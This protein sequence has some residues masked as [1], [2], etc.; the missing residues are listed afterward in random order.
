MTLVCL[1]WIGLCMFGL[2]TADGFLRGSLLGSSILFGTEWNTSIT[3]PQ[4]VRA[5]IP[6]MRK[7]ASKEMI[8]A[9]VELCETEVCFL[10]IQLI[11]TNVWLPKYTRHL[12]RLISNLQDPLQ[13]Q[14]LETILVCIVVPCFP[15]NNIVWITCVMN[16]RDQAR[17]AF[18]A[19]ICPFCDRTRMFYRPEDIGS[20]KIRA[21]YRHFRTIC[22][23]T[24][25][26]S[27]TDSCSSSLNWSSMHVVATLKNCWVVLFAGSQYLSTHFFAWPSMS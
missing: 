15:H 13:N 1:I 24:V 12:L 25:D 19:K 26:N 20:P 7:P 27:P 21:K 8:S 3:K 14:S 10:H 5:G 17:Q 9:S 2:T 22:E 23:Q 18:V 6:S 11:G 16:V 4:R